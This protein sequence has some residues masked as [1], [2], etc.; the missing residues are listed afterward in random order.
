MALTIFLTFDPAW[1]CFISPLSSAA[2]PSDSLWLKST[3]ADNWM[4]N[5][6][7]IDYF[8]KRHPL[9]RLQGDISLRM[10]QKMFDCI[11][12][13]RG[14]RVLEVGVTPDMDLIDSN[15]F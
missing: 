6:Q 1:P 13:R 9:M 3:N 15:F 7:P 10:R 8:N 12:L 11:P 4:V 14:M 5:T 2:F